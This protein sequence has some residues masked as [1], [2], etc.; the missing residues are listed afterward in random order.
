MLASSGT[1]ELKRTKA[2]F[3]TA[4]ITYFLRLY[5]LAVQENKHLYS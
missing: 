2:F 5:T 3:T 1:P 4:T